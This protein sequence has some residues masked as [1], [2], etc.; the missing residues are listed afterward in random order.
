MNAITM[1]DYWMGRDRTHAD[2]LTP[3]IR[4]NASVI[5]DKVNRLLHA[6]GRTTASVRS[7]WRPVEV[8]AATSGAA[9]G[10]KHLTARACDVADP[11]RSLARWCLANLD[12]LEFIGLWM[13]D[14]AYTHSWVHLQSVA[15]GSGRRVFRPF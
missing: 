3:D 4:A 5:V 10:S 11:D 13:E 6:A 2:E 15:P 12:Q 8:N 7:G 14:P 9:P 1:A